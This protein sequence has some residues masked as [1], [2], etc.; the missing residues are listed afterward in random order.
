MFLLLETRIRLQEESPRMEE[1]AERAGNFSE[2]NVAAGLACGV[3]TR[4]GGFQPP[5]HDH[6]RLEAAAT[7]NAIKMN[8]FSKGLNLRPP[9]MP[10]GRA[11]IFGGDAQEPRLTP[12]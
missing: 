12:D 7:R 10:V 2:A 8:H 9:P 3:T 11:L 1:S 5:S 4:N 6:R